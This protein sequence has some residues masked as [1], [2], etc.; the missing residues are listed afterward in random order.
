MMPTTDGGSPLVGMETGSLSMPNV[1]GAPEIRGAGG[2][3]DKPASGFGPPTIVWPTRSRRDSR[4]ASS[5]AGCF[6]FIRALGDRR[7]AH[8]GFDRRLGQGI[9]LIRD[10]RI[11]RR[12]VQR[13][14]LELGDDHGDVVVTARAV[15]AVGELLTGLQR[16]A[17]GEQHFAHFVAANHAG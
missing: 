12:R 17:G 16:I 7:G 10:Q 11:G 15:G 5:L 4:V 13:G 9:L 14:A 2:A 1:G 8:G 3:E 6:C